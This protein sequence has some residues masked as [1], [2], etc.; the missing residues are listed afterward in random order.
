MLEKMIKRATVC[1][2]SLW[3]SPPIFLNSSSGIATAQNFHKMHI[4]IFFIGK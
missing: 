4:Y 1:D 2:S 3:K